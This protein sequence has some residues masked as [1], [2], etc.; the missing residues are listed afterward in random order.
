MSLDLDENLPS[1]QGLF[2]DGNS[3]PAEPT[4]PPRQKKKTRP[5]IADRS[6]VKSK[7]FT[8]RGEEQVM[9]RL[10]ERAAATGL[11]VSSL[12]NR[13]AKEGLDRDFRYSIVCPFHDD[14]DIFGDCA[15]E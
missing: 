6:T 7:V 5:P 15:C 4:T 13:Y 3:E 10:A 14:G 9:D 12:L 11:T 1:P 8:F 2:G